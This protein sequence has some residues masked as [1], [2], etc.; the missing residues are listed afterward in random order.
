MPSK[1]TE[2][3]ASK[4]SHPDFEAVE[5]RK[6]RWIRSLNELYQAIDEWLSEAIDNK[7][8]D[9]P[10]RM[11]VA[12]H[13]DRTGTY[14]APAYE[15]SIGVATVK[16][17]PKGTYIV[18]ADGRIDVAASTGK[19]SSLFVKKDAWSLQGPESTRSIDLTEEAFLDLLQYL[20]DR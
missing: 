14:I 7:T 17:S 18:G 1:I 4:K 2:F 19:R 12:I 10:R 11:N 9:R 15:I 3:L 5:L 8:I 6:A 13:E 20:L 16:F